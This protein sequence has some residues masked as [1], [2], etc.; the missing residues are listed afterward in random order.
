MGE[1][2]ALEAD[3]RL[4]GGQRGAGRA[5][6]AD[7]ADEQQ[8]ERGEDARGDRPEQLLA[9]HGTLSLLTL[10]RSAAGRRARRLT[11]S[12]LSRDSPRALLLDSQG[13]L[14]GQ[15]RATTETQVE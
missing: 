11:W 5:G 12:R 1:S 9:R 15:R 8:N 10:V 3:R 6:R 13:K 7:V 4:A 14:S 2:A